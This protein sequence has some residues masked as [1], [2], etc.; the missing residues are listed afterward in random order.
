MTNPARA[1]GT[2]AALA[3]LIGWLPATPASAGVTTIQYQIQ[4][5]ILNAFSFPTAYTG[6]GTY[7]VRYQAGSANSL[8]A[9]P[10]TLVTLNVTAGP[11]RPGLLGAPG[12]FPT[13]ILTAL[14]FLSETG[15]VAATGFWTQTGYF[16][17]PVYPYNKIPMGNA[18]QGVAQWFI[19][20]AGYGV[21]TIASTVASNN[22]LIPSTVAQYV[23]VEVSRT[24]TSGASVPEPATGTMLALGLMAFGL[25]SAR[26]RRRHAR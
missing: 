2:A 8:Q 3:L 24:F 1:I 10:A 13:A 9:G 5:G 7:S 14:S 23:G 11:N 19:S 6:G 25:A 21:L 4:S 22:L 12:A 15:A 26:A 18:D 16:T 20:G 17:L